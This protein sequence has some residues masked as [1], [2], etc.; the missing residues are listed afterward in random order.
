MHAA[1]LDRCCRA[2]RSSCRKSP[3]LPA[4]GRDPDLKGSRHPVPYNF[5]IRKTSGREL[6]RPEI[7]NHWRMD[8]LLRKPSAVR[9]HCATLS[10][11]IRVDFIAAWL[12]CAY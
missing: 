11:I 4:L 8:Q 6:A 1:E 12:S 3:E 7:P 5:V 2:E 10:A 9:F